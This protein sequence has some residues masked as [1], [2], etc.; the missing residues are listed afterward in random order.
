MNFRKV[1]RE[2][3]E[4]ALG[5]W[6][7]GQNKRIVHEYRED[8]SECSLKKNPAL[9]V[10]RVDNG[11]F[12]MCFRCG[13]SGLLADGTATA[14]DAQN[15]L[16]ALTKTV[17]HKVTPEVN[18]PY[19]FIEMREEPTEEGVPYT[20]YKWLWKYSIGHNEMKLYNIGWSNKFNRCIIPIYEYGITTGPGLT[21]SLVGWIGRDCSPITSKAR[22]ALATAPAKYIT[23]KKSGY[24]RIYFHAPAK[25][26]TY[27]I[28]EDVV[29][30][31]RICESSNV[32]AYALLTTNIPPLFL[33]KLRR[34]RVILW[35]DNDQLENMATTVAKGSMLGCSISY[36]HTARDP[37]SYNTFA[38]KKTIENA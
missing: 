34:K 2:V 33:L 29:S 4:V 7:K 23:R 13:I 5:G 27:V 6:T 25:S 30:A 17:E 28:V 20:A 24:K 38:I 14:E 18:L 36:V 31:I 3:A 15:E 32:N 8:G 10:T 22:K 37:K 12:Y 11:W 9:S 26:N 16:D 19:D 21:K 35:L 1:P